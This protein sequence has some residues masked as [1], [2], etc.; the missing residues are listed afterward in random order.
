MGEQLRQ[1]AEA[2]KRQEPSAEVDEL[3]RRVIGCAIEV[4]KELG[5]GFPE[6]VYEEAMCV[7]LIDAGIGFERQPAI[8]V[9]F[10]ERLV[11]QGKIDLWIER[12]L[13]VE[14]KAVEEI[15]PKHKAQ[16]KAYLVATGCE[17]ALLM[18]FHEATLRDGITRVVWTQ[19]R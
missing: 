10:R 1:D 6:S 7:A 8:N 2:P 19:Q 9:F 17:L 14:L 4:H 13:V 11:G 15:H 3:A 5:P 16:A 12:K 18:N